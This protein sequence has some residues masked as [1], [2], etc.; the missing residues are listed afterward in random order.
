MA[1]PKQNTAE[2]IAATFLAY[3]RQIEAIQVPAHDLATWF[4]GPA[5]EDKL[6]ILR[7]GQ[8]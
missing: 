2:K 8:A 1:Q 3:Y 6:S 5:H 4:D 7:V